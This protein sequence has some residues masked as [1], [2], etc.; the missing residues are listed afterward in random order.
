M[1]ISFEDI[2]L[3]DVEL[4]H[5]TEYSFHASRKSTCWLG[6]QQVLLKLCFTCKRFDRGRFPGLLRLAVKSDKLLNHGIV[7]IFPVN[8]DADPAVDFIPDRGCHQA[9][10]NLREKLGLAGSA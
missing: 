10:Q 6:I 8:Q 5:R 2:F 9:V 7:F 1:S 3:W 4:S